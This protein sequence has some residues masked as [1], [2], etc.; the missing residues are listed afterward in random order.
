[1]AYT[2]DFPILS[3]LL[4]SMPAA[5]VLIWLTPDPRKARWIALITTLVDMLL[6][7][8]LLI[9]FDTSIAGYQF[10]EQASWIPS[11]NVQYL[12]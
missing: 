6:V 8:L 3:L 5:A 12:V 7:I 1:M 4:T 10:V 11:L 2:L 9:N